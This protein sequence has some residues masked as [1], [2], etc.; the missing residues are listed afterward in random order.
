MYTDLLLSKPH[1]SYVQ[2][3]PMVSLFLFYANELQA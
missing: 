3:D 1:K 2:E